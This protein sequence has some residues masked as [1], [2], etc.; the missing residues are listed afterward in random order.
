[1]NV[2]YNKVAH[3][4]V[5]LQGRDAGDCYLIIGEKD[6][7]YLLCNGKTKPLRAPKVK[8]HAHVELYEDN[9]P[10]IGAKLVNG[11]TLHDFEIITA[12]NT[13]KKN[14]CLRQGGTGIV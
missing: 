7:R 2:E 8:N 10:E 3:V 5:S 12:L 1:M 6:G 4:C 9:F 14:V 13:F 11:R